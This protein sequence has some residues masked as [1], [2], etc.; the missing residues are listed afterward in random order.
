MSQ[1][2]VSVLAAKIRELTERLLKEVYTNDSESK[3]SKESRR[4]KNEDLR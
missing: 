2:R 1:S 4:H 3:H